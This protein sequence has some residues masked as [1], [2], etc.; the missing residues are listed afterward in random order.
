MSSRFYLS[1]PASTSNSSLSS[2]NPDSL[3]FPK[4]LDRAS[5]LEPDFDPATFL[6]SLTNRF[7]T[8]EDLRTELVS[9]SQTI[10][11]ELVDLVND[12]YS[13]FLNLGSS[14]QG[15]EGK[16]EDVR[17]GLL[18]FERDVKG[19]RAKVEG[20]RTKISEFVQEKKEVMRELNLG[21]SLLEI[22]HRLG[23]LEVD[24]GLK[25]RFTPAV[26]QRDDEEDDADDEPWGAEW[27]DEVV[28]LDEEE[29]SSE[30][31]DVPIRLKSKVERYLAVKILAQKF[32]K[33]HP[34]LAAEQG[35]MKKVRE[36]VLLDVD[37]AIRAEP[38]V[39]GKQAMMRLRANIED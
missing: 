10:E 21:S 35:R 25:E 28:D 37:A 19:L 15:G 8:L 4:P 27:D 39:K 22:D 30:Q 3:P 14:L 1:S 23:E 2:A 34:F 16:I 9:L 36:T 6:S 11:N 18:G 20:E 38:N 24:L 7:Q 12:N 13:E 29:Y 32:D 31:R 26:E 5:F 17:V 33:E